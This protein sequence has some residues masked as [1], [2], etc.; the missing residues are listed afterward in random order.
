[1]AVADADKNQLMSSQATVIVPTYNAGPLWRQWIQAF[2]AQTVQPEVYVVDSSSGDDTVA[3]ARDAGFHVSIIDKNDFNHGGTRSRAIEQFCQTDIVIFL[4]QDALLAAPDAIEN[5]LRAF[6]DTN[7]GAVCGRQLPHK[8]A[9]PL[10]AHARTFNYPPKSCVKDASDI[11]TQG[12][13]VAFMSNSFAA[14]RV[15]IMNACHGFPSHTILCEDMYLAGKMVLDGYKVAYC[16]EAGVYHSHNYSPLEEF[17]RYFD[18]GV[19]HAREPWLRN[20]LG[21]ASGEGLRFVRSELRSIGMLRP[22]WWLQSL[23]TNAAKLIG[24]K[25]GLQERHLPLFIKKRLSMFVS[26]WQQDAQR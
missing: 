13:K 1:M 6:T 9:N 19:F 3:L 16:A 2:Q 8:N 14:Y 17:K 4:T 7:I 15:A 18:I 26:Y 10:A 5:I 12:L 24:F 25:I 22:R 20:R 21:G 11:A 23:L